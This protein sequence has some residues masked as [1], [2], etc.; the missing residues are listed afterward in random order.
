[1][2][3][4]AENEPQRHTFSIEWTH[5]GLLLEKRPVYPA[6]GSHKCE[7]RGVRRKCKEEELVTTTTTRSA[8]VCVYTYYASLS[9]A[10][11][12]CPITVV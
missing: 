10:L 2:H 11:L 5:K 1:M 7:Q 4:T 3:C 6:A 12:I 9:K 8:C